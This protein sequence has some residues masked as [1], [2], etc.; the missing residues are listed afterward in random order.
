MSAAGVRSVTVEEY[1]SNPEFKHAEFIDGEVV[2]RNLGSKNHSMI[3]VNAAAALNQYRKKLQ[4][5]S[6]HAGLHCKLAIRERLR[7]RIPDICYVLRDFD[8]PY[9]DGAPEFCIEIQSPED[10]IREALNK[11]DDYFAN[12]C[13][14]GWIVLPEE[15]SVLILRPSQSP[16][17]VGVGEMID[18]GDLLPGLSVAVADLFA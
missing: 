14:L 17:A 15:Q 5:G 11:F 3:A 9:L 2:E 6:G 13:R 8:G 16:H 10:L 1:L 18:G 12:G 4:R 7:Y